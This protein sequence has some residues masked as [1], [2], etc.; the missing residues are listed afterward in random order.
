MHRRTGGGS[1]LVEGLSGL[2][3]LWRLGGEEGIGVSG[4][5]A[6]CLELNAPPLPRCS[7]MESCELNA[8]RS[9]LFL[10]PER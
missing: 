4:T 3:D 1:G 7:E 9:I 8:P 6:V 2:L 5:L 10:V